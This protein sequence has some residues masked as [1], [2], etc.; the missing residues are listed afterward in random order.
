MTSSAFA[1]RR[2]SAIGVDVP[3]DSGYAAPSV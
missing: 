2:V 1:A 3:F